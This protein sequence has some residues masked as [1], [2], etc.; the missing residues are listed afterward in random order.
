MDSA[1]AVTFL[2]ATNKGV[3]ITLRADGRA[4][5]SNIVFSF[6]DGVARISVTDSRAKTTNLRRDARAVLHVSSRSFWH[7][8]SAS[9]VAELTEVTTQPGDA[10]GR[11]LLEVYNAVSD[12]PHPDPDEFFQAMVDDRRLVVRF[13][14][15]SF[16][17]M[18]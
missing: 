7:Y 14:P 11:E 10:T 3:L 1:A 5:S 13:R 18:V 4:Q 12:E 8:C 17:G 6:T 9:G 15:D 16:T 2:E